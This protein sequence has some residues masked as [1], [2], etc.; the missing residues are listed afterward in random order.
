[1]EHPLRVRIRGLPAALDMPPSVR[2][3]ESIFLECF[4]L[5]CLH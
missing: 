1:M 4:S 2:F 5:I 3:V